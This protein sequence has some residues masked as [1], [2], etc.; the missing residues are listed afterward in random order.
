MIDIKYQLYQ[1]S[2]QSKTSQINSLQS[3]PTKEIIVIFEI[4]NN[5]NSQIQVYRQQQQINYLQQLS[6]TLQQQSPPQSEAAASNDVEMTSHEDPIMEQVEE[7]DDAIEIDRFLC[8]LVCKGSC[9]QFAYFFICCYGFDEAM[10]M[11]GWESG[12]DMDSLKSLIVESIKTLECFDDSDTIV[13]Y[14]YE[15]VKDNTT[16]E[17]EKREYLGEFLASLTEKDTTSFIDDIMKALNEIEKE[18]QDLNKKLLET[19]KLQSELKIKEVA[20]QERNDNDKFEN[21]YHKMS[22]EEQKNRDF[23]LARYAYEEEDVDENGDI[24]L[25]D[26]TDSNTPKASLTVNNNTK[27]IVDEEKAKREKAKIE[28][29][30][31]VARDKELLAKQKRDEEKKKTTKKEKRRLLLDFSINNTQSQIRTTEKDYDRFNNNKQ[32]KL[33][34]HSSHSI[35]IEKQLFLLP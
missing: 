30:K 6:Q 15:L 1:V 10:N 34:S 20:D 23:L 18:N 32:S 14:I 12:L 8:V 9:N 4:D 7:T 25:S 11:F 13:D 33:I 29:E 31:K 24:I 2:G 27:R 21:P 26:Q 19:M 28:N 5:Y 3:Y 16:K 22:R 35:C 17:D